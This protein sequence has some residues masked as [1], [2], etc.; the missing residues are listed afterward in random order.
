MPVD[1]GPVLPMSICICSRHV[2]VL[3]VVANTRDKGNESSNRSDLSIPALVVPS[4]F[5]LM[6]VYVSHS[7]V[8]QLRCSGSAVDLRR[9]GSG[10]RVLLSTVSLKLLGTTPYAFVVQ[11]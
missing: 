9:K 7:Y 1:D 2:F 11:S 3:R 5:M 6:D 10:V 8:E 4:D